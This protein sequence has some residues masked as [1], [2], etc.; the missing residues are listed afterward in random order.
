M[1]AAQGQHRMAGWWMTTLEPPVYHHNQVPPL[2]LGSCL[3]VPHARQ[4]SHG[5]DEREDLGVCL[6]SGLLS[7]C[8]PDSFSKKLAH[9]TLRD[10]SGKVVGMPHNSGCMPGHWYQMGRVQLQSRHVKWCMERWIWWLRSCHHCVVMRSIGDLC[11]SLSLS[12]TLLESNAMTKE[13]M[14]WYTLPMMFMKLKWLC[15]S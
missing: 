2:N 7:R 1:E 4:D 5:W 13:V 14:S 8:N 6:K 9:C 10:S 11:H 15:M 12:L 3:V